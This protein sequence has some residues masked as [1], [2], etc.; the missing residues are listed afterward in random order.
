MALPKYTKIR[1]SCR[2][3][4]IDWEAQD[5]I[6]QIQGNHLQAVQ[7]PEGVSDVYPKPSLSGATGAAAEGKGSAD[8]D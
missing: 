4:S 1:C 7:G 3:K 2:E 8:S 5:A 6:H